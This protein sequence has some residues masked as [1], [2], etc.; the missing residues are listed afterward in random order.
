MSHQVQKSFQKSIAV[1]L[2]SS[3]ALFAILFQLNGNN[4]MS[5]FLVGLP[6]LIAG[7]VSI[8]GVVD[9][10]YCVGEPNHWKKVTAFVIHLSMVVILLTFIVANI[11]DIVHLFGF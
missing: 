2:L 11:E 6:I 1:L 7:I 5:A 4:Q 3:F 8:C 10:L 9:S